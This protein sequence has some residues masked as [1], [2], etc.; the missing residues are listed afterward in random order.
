MIWVPPLP[1]NSFVESGYNTATLFIYNA[2]VEN[3]DYYMC[4][5]GSLEGEPEEENEAGIYVFVAGKR[6]RR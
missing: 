3:T 5:Y 1:E 2:S 4:T 6:W